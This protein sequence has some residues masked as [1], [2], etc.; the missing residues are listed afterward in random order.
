MEVQGRFNSYSTNLTFAALL[1]GAPK[2]N[3][4]SRSNLNRADPRRSRQPI[5]NPLLALFLSRSISFLSPT[6]SL[7]LITKCKSFVRFS[8]YP[9]GVPYSVY[10][11]SLVIFLFWFLSVPSLFLPLSF[12]TNWLVSAQLLIGSPLQLYWLIGEACPRLILTYS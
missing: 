12:A 8:F 9:V 11:S 5:T 6:L 7:P 10:F 1:M 3:S 2:I 4:L